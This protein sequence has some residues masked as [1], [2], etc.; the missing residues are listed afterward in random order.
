M[1]LPAAAAGWGTSKK[2]QWQKSVHTP[3]EQETLS[4]N[5]VSMRANVFHSEGG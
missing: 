3:F 2:Q 5:S 1:N 4:P